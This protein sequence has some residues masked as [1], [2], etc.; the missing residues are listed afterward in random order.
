MNGARTTLPDEFPLTDSLIA[1]AARQGIRSR[2]VVERFHERFVL[3]H[4][5]K[6]YT[7][8]DHVATWQTWLRKDIDEGRIRTEPK[9]VVSDT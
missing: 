5:S 4:R 6:G 8:V 9:P 3:Q 2:K 1:Y 7:N